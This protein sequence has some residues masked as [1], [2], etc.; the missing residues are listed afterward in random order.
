MLDL[1]DGLA[2]IGVV[3]DVRGGRTRGD[4]DLSSPVRLLLHAPLP[5]PLPTP[6]APTTRPGHRCC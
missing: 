3:D 1:T 4:S 6:E 2:E 5:A